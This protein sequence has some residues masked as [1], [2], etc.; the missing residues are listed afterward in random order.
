MPDPSPPEPSIPSKEA[1]TW[2]RILNS[3][4]VTALATVLV[5]GIFSNLVIGWTQQRNKEREVALLGY[6]EYLS[7]QLKSVEQV[8]DLVGRLRAA[9]ED[10]ITIT[11]PN[12]EPARFEGKDRAELRREAI[13]VQKNFNA[14]EQEWRRR[15]ESLGFL[16]VY[17]HQAQPGTVDAWVKMEKVLNAYSACAEKWHNEHVGEHDSDVTSTPCRTEQAATSS[18]LAELTKQLAKAQY[19]PG[20]GASSATRSRLLTAHR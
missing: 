18:S 7:A 10:L 9:A 20:V 4:T 15:R 1:G 5:T 2:E 16:M 17:Y 12:F 3:S 19:A 11:S 6:K 8:Y 13:D 14:V